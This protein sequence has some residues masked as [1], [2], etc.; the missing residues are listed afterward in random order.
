MPFIISILAPDPV[1]LFE[2]ARP[3]RRLLPALAV[4]RA[5]V[6]S[7]GGLPQPRRQR[8]RH[9]HHVPGALLGQDR[10]AVAVAMDKLNYLS[11]NRTKTKLN[12]LG[13]C[14]CLLIALSTSQKKSGPWGP[15]GFWPQRLLQLYA[16]THLLNGLTLAHLDISS[17]KLDMDTQRALVTLYP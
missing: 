8:A 13:D 15:Q 14:F 5:C 7:H 11:V 10:A 6:A 1:R 2:R 3:R 17:W 12:R 16:L 9:G 4:P